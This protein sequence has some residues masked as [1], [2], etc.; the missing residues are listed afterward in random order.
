MGARYLDRVEVVNIE[1][2]QFIQIVISLGID[3]L[4]HQR[5]D[6]V[7][8]AEKEIFKLLDRKRNRN[9]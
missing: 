1:R 6:G 9:P 4:V 5:Q 3:Q 8:V 7:F 2:G